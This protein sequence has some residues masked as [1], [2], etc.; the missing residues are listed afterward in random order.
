MA[1]CGH[2]SYQAV[3]IPHCCAAGGCEVKHRT[4]IR[5]QV[6]DHLAHKMRWLKE[7]WWGEWMIE[8]VAEWNRPSSQANI[9]SCWLS[10]VPIP[11][12]LSPSRLTQQK[13]SETGLAR[14]SRSK[15]EKAKQGTGT[16]KQKQGCL[17][18]LSLY[19]EECALLWRF[20]KALLWNSCWYCLCI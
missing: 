7:L 8:W 18:S 4:V 19:C 14:G 13:H 6:P 1:T 20:L 2:C 17:C 12:P 3:A 10:P 11:P 15:E 5:S 16:S 9:L